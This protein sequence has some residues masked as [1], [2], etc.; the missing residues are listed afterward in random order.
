[1][2]EAFLTALGGDWFAV[3]SAG[4]ETAELN[5][6]AVAAM[7]EI[8]IDISKNG[9]KPAFDFFKEG[10]R[11]NYVT[12]VCDDASAERC[13]TFTGFTKRLHW[14]FED[15][16]KLTGTYEERFEGTRKIRD[17]IKARIEQW[18]KEEEK[19]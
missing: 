3:E 6:L 4:L 15:P 9:P 18:L 10:R 2:A 13:P 5:P 16:L 7:K 17:K 12:T 8:G 11:Y 19:A 14:P 1:M